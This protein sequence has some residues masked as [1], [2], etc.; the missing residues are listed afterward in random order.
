MAG[1][2]FSS[3]DNREPLKIFEQG[4]NIRVALWENQVDSSM[5]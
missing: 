4:T 2:A 3:V 5:C 1:P